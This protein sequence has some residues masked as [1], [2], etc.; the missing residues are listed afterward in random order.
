MTTIDDKYVL[1]YSEE[2]SKQ[3]GFFN[4]AETPAN[5]NKLRSHIPSPVIPLNQLATQHLAAASSSGSSAPGRTLMLLTNG[6]LHF[7]SQATPLS[8]LSSLLLSSTGSSSNQLDQFFD[9]YTPQEACAMCFSLAIGSGGQK[10]P[11]GQKEELTRRAIHAAFVHGGQPQVNVMHTNANSSSASQNVVFTTEEFCYSYLH[12]GLTMLVSR[13][14][15]P[16]WFK[17]P[18]LV[19]PAKKP[20]AK[21]PGDTKKPVV[22]PSKVKVLFDGATLDEIR[23]PLY[24]LQMLMREYFHPAV[25]ARS[26]T[27]GITW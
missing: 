2:S 17:A 11:P 5:T 10:P 24:A 4:G 19:V 3:D 6:G 14:L 18:I 9:A 21:K 1:C 8:S 7:L 22:G 13:L 15:R 12:D 26:C 27:R 23:K 20:S 16:I 25:Y